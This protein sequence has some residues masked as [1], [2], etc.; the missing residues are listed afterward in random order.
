M[1][2]D[3][4]EESTLLA[5]NNSSTDN[6]LSTQYNYTDNGLST[7][8]SSTD[9]EAYLNQMPEELKQSVKELALCQWQDL[10]SKELAIIIERKQGYL[11][12]QYLN[13]L[14]TSERSNSGLSNGKS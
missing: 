14:I 4:Y 13:P 9:K 10:S 5:H 7:E 6:S 11:L 8:F 2:S 12:N 3:R 1:K